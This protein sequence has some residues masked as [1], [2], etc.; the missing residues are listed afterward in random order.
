MV[1]KRKPTGCTFRPKLR[2][3]P[4]LR[5]VLY[6]FTLSQIDSDV[7][8]TLNHRPETAAAGKATPIGCQAVS[9]TVIHK[10]TADK[11][12]INVQAE[13]L[14]S[15]GHSREYQFINRFGG[16]VGNKA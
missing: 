11:Q 8:R 5:L 6:N 15:I 3:L 13:V 4:F 7:T 16:T 12:L 1:F 2:L 9:R 14:F 10:D